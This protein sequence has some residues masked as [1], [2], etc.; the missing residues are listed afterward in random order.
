MVHETSGMVY[1]KLIKT[2]KY[3]PL[4]YFTQFLQFNFRSNQ[5]QRIFEAK[6]DFFTRLN[7]PETKTWNFLNIISSKTLYFQN[8]YICISKQRECIAIHVGQAGIQIGNACWELYCL[9]HGLQ[10]DGY[11]SPDADAMRDDSFT[12]FFNETQSGKYVPRTL[13]TD[14]EPTVVGTKYI[15]TFWGIV[16]KLLLRIPI[17]YS[18]ALNNIFGFVPILS[19]CFNVHQ[20]FL[21]LKFKLKQTSWLFMCRKRVGLVRYDL[22]SFN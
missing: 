4:E 7:T 10:P 16:L 2:D 6:L 14:L 5:N 13:F 17:H 8:W 22:F 3:R 12:S 19:K 11:I 21:F 15:S 9:E 20:I 18:I 1:I